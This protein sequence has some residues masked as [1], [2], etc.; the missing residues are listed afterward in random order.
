MSLAVFPVSLGEPKAD[1]LTIEPKERN[2]SILT[3]DGSERLR[4]QSVG[5]VYV[6]KGV[7][8]LKTTQVAIFEEFLKYD[9]SYG[10]FW[11]KADWFTGIGYVA[12]DWAFKLIAISENCY[13]YKTEFSCV[14]LMQKAV[15]VPDNGPAWPQSELIPGYVF[16]RYGC[17]SPASKVVSGASTTVFDLE[18]SEVDKKSWRETWVIDLFLR[19]TG[20][21]VSGPHAISDITGDTITVGTAMSVTPSNIHSIR[22]A[23]YDEV[24]ASQKVFVFISD[25][26]NNFVS[27]GGQAYAIMFS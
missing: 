20:V 24:V 1:G 3:E 7:L 9:S 27:D 10:D 13:G 25:D 22:F 2:T 4:T 23:A 21:K 17:I 11:F 5:D 14:F 16:H 8:D 15:D 6:V 12:D 18:V 26:G 19:S